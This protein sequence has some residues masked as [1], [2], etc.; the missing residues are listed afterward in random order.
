MRNGFHEDGV[1]NHRSDKRFVIHGSE[2]SFIKF[3]MDVQ[4]DGLLTAVVARPPP[5]DEAQTARALR[6]HEA[7]E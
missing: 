4:F 7:G 1:R 3:G 5:L 2:G 6:L